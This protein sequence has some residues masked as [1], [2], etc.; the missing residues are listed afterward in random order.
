MAALFRKIEQVITPESLEEVA[1]LNGSVVKLAVSQLKPHK[2]DVSSTFTSDALL[3]APDIL[4]EQLEVV[5]RRWLTHG[6]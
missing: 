6:H 2:S 4:F 3:H 5:F 1:R